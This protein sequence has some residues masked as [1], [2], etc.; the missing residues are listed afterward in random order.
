M[1]PTGQPPRVDVRGLL[2]LQA[3]VVSR[4]QALAAGLAPHDVRRLVRRREWAAV[5]PGVY[6]DHTG[7]LTWLQRAWAG[8]LFAA[9]AALCHISA[10]RTDDPIIHVAIDRARHVVAPGGVR[11]HHLGDFDRKVQ[12]NLAPPRV[13]VEEA[14]IDVAAEAGDDITAIA[15]V[16]DAVQAR[17]TTA[18]RLLDALERRTR[19]ARR[20]LLRS[21]LTD[22]ANGTHSA[23]EHGYLTRVERPHGLPR[24]GRQVVGIGRGGRAVERDAEYRALALIV[25]LDGRLFHDS[26]RARDR[27]LDRDLDAA[28]SGRRTVRL[29]W[30]QVFDRGCE[31]AVRIGRLLQRLGWTGEPHPCPDCADRW[32]QIRVTG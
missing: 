28:V 11:I 17:R 19:I 1:I 20:P 27:D 9:P 7:P 26:A 29:G 6:V 8:V 14:V 13:R 5:H 4:R 15:T 22:V 25:E 16:A 21:V 32:P 30:G 2:E 18:A 31:T 23:L 12:W 3:G 24:A 10:L